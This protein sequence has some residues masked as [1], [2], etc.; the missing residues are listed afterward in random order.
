MSYLLNAV[1]IGS[2]VEKD[3][4]SWVLDLNEVVVGMEEHV[5]HF[6]HILQVLLE[7]E[8]PIRVTR[9]ELKDSSNLLVL[10]GFYWIG[11]YSF[12]EVGKDVG[13]DEPERQTVIHFSFFEL[14]HDVYHGSYQSLDC[15]LICD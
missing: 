4:G 15:L 3:S 7:D 1:L 2:Q 14:K 13:F 12:D 6:N 11:D 8:D 9:T 10:R 5:H